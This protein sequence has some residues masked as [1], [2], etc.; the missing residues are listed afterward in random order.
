MIEL[1]MKLMLKNEVFELV[2][3]RNNPPMK[4]VHIDKNKI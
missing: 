2:E 4:I 1:S 3:I